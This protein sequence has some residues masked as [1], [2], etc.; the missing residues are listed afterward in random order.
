[1]KCFSYIKE[2]QIYGESSRMLIICDKL[3]ITVS[4]VRKRFIID[5]TL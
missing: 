5:L 2:I 1:M 3:Y 4:R